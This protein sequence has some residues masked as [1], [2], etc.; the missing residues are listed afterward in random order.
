VS[1]LKRSEQTC[2]VVRGR[3]KTVPD[4]FLTPFTTWMPH[5]DEP[6][7]LKRHLD[8]NNPAREEDYSGVRVMTDNIVVNERIGKLGLLRSAD[9][10]FNAA[11]MRR[12]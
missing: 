1:G 12:P 7:W 11:V 4:T 2:M 9:P 6:G 3:V 10:I 8:S 5:K